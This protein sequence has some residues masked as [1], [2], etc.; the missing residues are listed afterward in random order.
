MRSCS[1]CIKFQSQRAEPLKSSPMPSLPWK[2]IAT[3]LFEWKKTTYLLIVDYYSR[4][5]EIARLDCLTAKAVVQH[6]KSIFARHGIPDEVIS[7]NGPQYASEYYASFAKEYGFKHI[8]SS[9]YHPQGN[10]E[11]ERAV[12]TVKNLLKKSGDLYLALL[13][14]R[15]T[16][17]E[18]GYTP[19]EL[20]MGRK[21]PTTVPIAMKQLAP[22]TPDQE[23]VKVRD[24]RAKESRRTTMTLITE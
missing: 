20:L 1:E 14:Y 3:D 12:Q 2:R 23:E 18:L 16:P 10:G 8:T 11:A 17:L 24:N 19:S 22:K 15:A 13:A 6:T 21:L 4:W 5:I 7:D 9:P